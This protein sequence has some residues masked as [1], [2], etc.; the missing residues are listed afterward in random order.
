MVSNYN[1]KWMA[2]TLWEVLISIVVT[3]LIV[4][5]S[6]SS[7]MMFTRILS[8]DQQRLNDLTEMVFLERELYKMMESSETVE[9]NS[10]VLFFEFPDSL[11]F[12]EFTDSTFVISS[13]K[14]DLE[15]EYPLS[16]WSITFLNNETDHVS[17]IEIGCNYKGMDYTFALKKKYPK[18]FLYSQLRK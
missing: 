3:S 2:F 11:S 6:Y 8:E 10:N 18:K 14:T 7:Y 12:I 5:F 9:A 1:L 13:D 16:G 4:T 15:H 17:Y